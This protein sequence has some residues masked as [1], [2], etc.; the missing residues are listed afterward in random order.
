MK[1][2]VLG[3]APEV[4]ALIAR[5]KALGL[6][7]FDEVWEGTHHVAPAPMAAHALLDEILA[8]SLYPY[9]QAAG[10]V[11]SGP[12]NLGRPGNFRVPD[13]GYHRGKPMGTWVP[14]AA[15]VVEIVSPDDEMYAKFGFYAAQGVEEI[16]VADPDE[17]VVRCFLRDGEGFVAAPTSALLAVGA[18]DLTAGVDWP[19]MQ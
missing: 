12:F 15:I 13:R 4:E 19:P 7:L 10:L 14:S 5:R 6:D 9:A 8:V 11:G 16:I 2:V 17:R 18:D 1:T 3:P